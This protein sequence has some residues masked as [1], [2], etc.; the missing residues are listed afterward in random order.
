MQHRRRC[1][2]PRRKLSEK[3]GE[4]MPERGS[5]RRRHLISPLA[6]SVAIAQLRRPPSLASTTV[7]DL[8]STQGSLPIRAPLTLMIAPI[9]AVQT[10]ARR[11]QVQGRGH[12]SFKL[13]CRPSRAGSR[14]SWCVAHHS[15]LLPLQL[16][17]Q[18]SCRCTLDGATYVVRFLTTG[19]VPNSHNSHRLS[20]WRRGEVR[21]VSWISLRWLYL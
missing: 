18:K 16:I 17:Y 8:N 2:C 11:E 19:C 7:I 14:A 3:P 12:H 15:L 13:E 20:S 21:S 10:L 4:L 9:V 5:Q 6:T 1:L